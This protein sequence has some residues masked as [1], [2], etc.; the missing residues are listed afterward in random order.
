MNSEDKKRLDACLN[1]AAE[2]LYRN[3][4]SEDLETDFERLENTIREKILLHV[5]PKIALFFIQKVTGT[6]RGRKR[7][8]KTTVGSIYLRGKQ[9]EKL[10]IEPYKRI[11]P[12]FQKCC[13]LISAN[14][15]YINGENIIE[16]LT[17]LKMSDTTLQRQVNSKEFEVTEIKEKIKEVSLDG[18]K[19]R[20]RSGQK[21]VSCYFRDYKAARVNNHY[22]GAFFQE[23]TS[24]TDWINS[25]ETEEIITCIGDGHEGIWNLF[26]EISVDE[27]RREILDWYHRVENLYKV[28]GS[29]KRRSKAKN[30]LWVGKTKEASKLFVGLQCKNAANFRAYL[31]KHKARI[32]NYQLLQKKGLCSIGSGAV[33]SAV[34]EISARIKISGAQWKTENVN[35]I[36]KLRCWYLNEQLAS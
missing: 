4:C 12:F 17:G 2:I 20:I 8:I 9:A 16:I 3:T 33:E 18:G 31:A 15:S 7:Q 22:Y 36:L 21:G 26:K 10:G 24:L 23:N 19:V 25:Q 14:N 28:S 5:S 35:Q 30:M 27:K 29:L 13:L 34:K 32:V 1:E 11:S 6:N